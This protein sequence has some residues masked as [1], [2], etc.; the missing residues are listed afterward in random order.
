[1][2]KRI[3]EEA[4]P[5]GSLHERMNCVLEWAKAVGPEELPHGF[6]NAVWDLSTLVFA[7]DDVAY[8][9]K[10][11]REVVPASRPGA[12]RVRDGGGQNLWRGELAR[13]LREKEGHP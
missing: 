4:G 3:T 8:D 7:L 12:K 11:G 13:Y 5:L 6:W 2:N 1:M 10:T 9:Q